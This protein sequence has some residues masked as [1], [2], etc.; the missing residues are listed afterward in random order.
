MQPLQ[1][2]RRRHGA[3]LVEEGL[4]FACLVGMRASH[5]CAQ[6]LRW[7]QD[8]HDSAL[9]EHYGTSEVVTIN[10]HTG[11]VT[12]IGPKRMYIVRAPLT[13]HSPGAPLCSC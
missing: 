2:R 4:S 8:E 6:A 11:A 9:L 3:E 7:P 13:L 10:V 12:R 5:T 1:W